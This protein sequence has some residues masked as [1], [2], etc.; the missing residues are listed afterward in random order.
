MLQI[1]LL[2]KIV[3]IFT[4]YSKINFKWVKEVTSLKT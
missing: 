3:C 2:G 1:A 4:L